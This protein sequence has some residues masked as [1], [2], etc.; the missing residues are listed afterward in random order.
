MN[1]TMTSLAQRLIFPATMLSG[2][3]T[4][5]CLMQLEVAPEIAALVSVV[6]FGF[7]L[8]PLWERLLP[9]RDDWSHS[10]ADVK[11]DVLHIIING[12]IPKLWTPVQVALL[13]GVTHWASE[14][15][16][17]GLWPHQ[18]PLMVQLALMLLIAEF[19]RYWVH[20]AAHTLPLLWRFHGVHHSPNRL[21]FLNA[22]R[23]HPVEKLLLQLP[24]VAP[25]IVLGVNVETIALYFTFNTIHGFFQHSNI[26][27]KLGVLNYIFSMT[28]LHRWHH[29]QVIKESDTN[30]G[31][32]LIIWDLIFGTFH[33]P[34]DSEVDTIG[35]LNDSYPKD[36]KGQLAAPFAQTDMSKPV[37]Y[38]STS[39]TAV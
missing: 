20:R 14:K 11:T 5:Y 37:D 33:W 3:F 17:A 7:L 23:F 8:I 19:G 2:L 30:F 26:R 4:T 21:Y 28:E 27:L 34:K 32:N 24:E 9:Y 36:Y 18:W 16:G 29:S 31:N 38:A 35:L 13:V 15:F 12:I 1:N 10:D 25:F 6:L 39:E 22:G